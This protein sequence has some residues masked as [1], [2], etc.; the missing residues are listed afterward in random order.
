[1]AKLPVYVLPLGI[2]ELPYGLKAFDTYFPWAYFIIAV[3]QSII[4]WN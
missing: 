3:H 1:M 4:F 2:E